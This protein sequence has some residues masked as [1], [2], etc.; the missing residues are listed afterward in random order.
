M[1]IKPISQRNIEWSRELLGLN[2]DP[3]YSIGSY[4]C[5]ITCLAMVCN[6]Y[7]FE[8]TPLTINNK[9][10][11]INGFS[12]GG[13]YNWGS[14]K[15]IV[16]IDE[17]WIGYYP[18]PLTNAQ[19]AVINDAID[20]GYPVMVEIDFNPD[21]LSADMHFVLII[22]RDVNDENDYTINDPW[23]GT[24]ISL[25]TYLKNTKP[26]AKKSIEQVI[27]YK[28]KVIEDLENKYDV[29]MDKFI[30]LQAERDALNNNYIA[31]GDKYTKDLKAKTST[32]ETIQKE[33][34][35]LRNKISMAKEVL[36]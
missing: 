33:N 6:Y 25:K 30:T 36:K 35:E 28:G 9:L 19:I 15:N 29:L 27:I 3:I 14:I 21:T 22:A 10:I 4:G 1:N 7:G 31:L 23:T 26:T 11:D 32:I 20:S 17:Q 16:G 34:S 13:F 8:E 2:T 24:T 12:N 5:L 18:N